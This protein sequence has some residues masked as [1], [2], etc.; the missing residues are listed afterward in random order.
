MTMLA[1]LYPGQGTQRVGMGRALSARYP[2]AVEVFEHVDSMLGFSL[3]DVCFAGPPDVLLDTKHAQC[4]VFSCSM[5]AT[6]V[7]EARQVRP[8]FAAGH[9]VGVFGALVVARAMDLGDALQA[10]HQ[11]GALMSALPDTGAM[12]LVLGLDE[13]QM[14][15]LC[16][17]AR[18]ADV[19]DVGLVNAPRQV[20]ISGASD[21]VARC[22]ALASEAGALR[23]IP[24]RVSNAFH[25]GLMAG[26]ARE[27]KR[28]ARDLRI[29][30]PEI[31][32][33]LNTTGEL[34][35]SPEAIREDLVNQMVHTV[36][37]ADC[38]TALARAGAT[39]CVEVGDSKALVAFNRA[40]EPRFRNFTLADPTALD[41]FRP[42][43]GSLPQRGTA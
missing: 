18:G 7:L 29:S 43:A 13:V 25:S 33:A 10:V 34:T 35:Q 14:G 27:W 24:L 41:R 22:G 23:V 42:V 9:S 36:R 40:I 1:F 8:Q 11:R 26:A 4:A 19:L 28:L 20:V 38:V 30:P 12:T 37:W 39:D 21:A 32:V 31:P 15:A 17:Q 5:A 3:S 16:D 6:A 2:E